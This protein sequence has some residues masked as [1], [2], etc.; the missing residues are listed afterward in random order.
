MPDCLIL[1]SRS[2]RN[3]QTWELQYECVQQQWSLWFLESS[4]SLG[5]SRI[6][7]WLKQDH[8]LRERDRD[9]AGKWEEGSSAVPHLSFLW[10]FSF[11]PPLGENPLYPTNHDGCLVDAALLHWSETCS[12]AF[13]IMVMDLVR[14][15]VWLILDQVKGSFVMCCR[16]QAKQHTWRNVQMES[17]KRLLLISWAGIYLIIG[18]LVKLES[19]VIIV[20]HGLTACL[21]VY[22]EILFHEGVIRWLRALFFKDSNLHIW[23]LIPLQYFNQGYTVSGWYT[24]KC[25][26]NS[27]IIFMSFQIHFVLCRTHKVSFWRISLLLFSISWKWMRCVKLQNDKSKVHLINNA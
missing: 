21:K 13:L 19:T 17:I 9:K 7:P 25:A 15:M 26:D 23:T 14:I 16:C 10:P 18:T 12:S 5:Q 22:A 3:T 20:F 24:L 2:H 8:E 27:A 6:S 1:L 4:M 11:P